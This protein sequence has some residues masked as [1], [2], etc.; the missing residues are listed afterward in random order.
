MKI[1]ME[2]LEALF[3]GENTLKDVLPSLKEELE[4][5]D[6]YNEVMIN[7]LTDNSEEIKRASNEIDGLYGRLFKA[8][9]FADGALDVMEPRL[10]A[11]IKAKAE[12][13]GIKMTDG[14]VAAQAADE[15]S[16][17]RRVRA[18]LFGYT[19]TLNRSLFTLSAILKYEGSPKGVARPLQDRNNQEEPE[20]PNA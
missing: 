10:K 17:Y 18:Y 8:W 12:K 5:A 4:R 15:V 11:K 13:D 3:Y 20:Y 9:S 16:L 14:A 19:E 2:E 6:Y 7:N 1:K